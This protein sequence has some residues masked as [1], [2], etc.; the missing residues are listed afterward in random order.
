MRRLGITLNRLGLLCFLF[1]ATVAGCSKSTLAIDAVSSNSTPEIDGLDRIKGDSLRAT[2]QKYYSA[3]A[4]LR[5]NDT[6]GYR[7]KNFQ[8]TVLF[9]DYV[10]SMQESFSGW[11]LTKLR[12]ESVRCNDKDC[13]IRIG[14]LETVNESVARKFA[15]GHATAM[16]HTEDTLWRE[17]DGNWVVLDAGGRTHVPLNA[18][19]ADN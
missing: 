15:M 12:I 19:M 9:N 16:I 5:W 3:E 6:Y 14:F 11:T 8:Q 13:T 7:S 2:V 10:H 18:N 17:T 4:R 1:V